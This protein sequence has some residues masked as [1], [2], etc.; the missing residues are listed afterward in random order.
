MKKSLITLIAVASIMFSTASAMAADAVNKAVAH[1]T[2][3]FHGSIV[4][5]PCAMNTHEIINGKME[6][7]CYNDQTG[8]MEVKPVNIEKLLKNGEEYETIQYKLKS[9]KIAEN[10]Y[11]VHMIFN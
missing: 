11:T 5:T 6:S 7:S 2:I 4:A 10:L 1:G 8:K 3:S 9:T